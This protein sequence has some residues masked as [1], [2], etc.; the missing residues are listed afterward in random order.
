M[1]LCLDMDGYDMEST[2]TSSNKF[3]GVDMRE[4][5]EAAKAIL[6]RDYRGY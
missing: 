4:F 1:V 5:G 3:S 2:D 6:A